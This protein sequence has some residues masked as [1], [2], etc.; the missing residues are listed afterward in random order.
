MDRREAISRVSMLVG[1]TIIGA[2]AFLESGC[3][4]K[5]EDAGALFG[6]DRMELLNEIC[7][8]ILPETK[9]S[10]GAKAANVGEFLAI[11]VNDCYEPEDQEIFMN[12]IGQLERLCRK[13]YRKGFMKCDPVQRKELLIFLDAEQK[14]YM[15]GKD[16]E[17]PAHYFR[18]IKEL[19]LLG[20]FTSEIGATQ[21][22][23]YVAI[24]G[25]YVGVVPYQKGDRAWCTF[26]Y[27]N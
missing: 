2:D 6:R 13:K 8:T 4:S 14:E 11:V 7:E 23:R 25:K 16:D 3:R 24:P 20:F 5:P 27:F 22:L 18:M 21:A 19:T 1:G 10:P 9:A 17:A 15:N 26:D 12:G